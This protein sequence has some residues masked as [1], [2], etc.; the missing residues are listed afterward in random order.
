MESKPPTLT[1]RVPTFSYGTSSQAGFSVF[2]INSGR[3][4]NVAPCNSNNNESISTRPPPREKREGRRPWT[5]EEDERLVALV[6]T[7]IG[8]GAKAYDWGNWAERFEGREARGLQTRWVNSLRPKVG[9]D[10]HLEPWSPKEDTLLTQLVTRGSRAVMNWSQIAL[11]FP[12]RTPTAVSGRWDVIGTIER[13]EAQKPDHLAKGKWTPAEDEALLKSGDERGIGKGWKDIEAEFPGR[14]K[15][16]LK[17]RYSGMQ[18]ALQAVKALSKLTEP[19]KD[20]PTA[21]SSHSALSDSPPSATFPSVSSAAAQSSNPHKSYQSPR[22][23]ISPGSLPPALAFPRQQPTSSSPSLP[24]LADA[25]NSVD[26][27]IP[28]AFHPFPLQIVPP[29]PVDP[30]P[31]AR[32]PQAYPSVL[33]SAA[34]PTVAPPRSTTNFPSVFAPSLFTCVPVPDI[35][36]QQHQHQYKVIGPSRMPVPRAPLSPVKGAANRRL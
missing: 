26:T 34:G 19:E 9:L 8:V 7:R 20:A 24:S 5:Q 29:R 11:S 21:S 16:A 14:S 1:G 6:Q 10:S 28:H 15:S 13:R 35:F 27:S 32:Q 23:S 3:P 12:T 31:P 30:F 17:Q 36:Y 4:S 22:I 25:L 33:N 18:R 2:R